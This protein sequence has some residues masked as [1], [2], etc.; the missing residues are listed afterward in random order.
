MAVGCHFICNFV[1]GEDTA[2]GWLLWL[3]SSPA[4]NK[5]YRRLLEI[6]WSIRFILVYCL[7]SEKT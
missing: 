6:N 4:S 3:L 7:S 2:H 1:V 5:K